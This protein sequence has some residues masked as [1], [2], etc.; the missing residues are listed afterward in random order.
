MTPRSSEE[1]IVGLLQR[2][3]QG[4]S[5]RETCRQSGIA[6]ETFYRWRRKYGGMSVGQAQ[7]LT[8]LETENRRLKKLVAELRIDRAA[9]R[10]AL[11]RELVSTAA[12]RQVTQRWQLAF[13]LSERRACRILGM[14]RSTFR[15]ERRAQTSGTAP[16][17]RARHRESPSRQE[18]RWTSSEP[19]QA[20]TAGPDRS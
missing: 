5:V 1:E 7:G 9:L 19:R 12:R 15:Y 18:E 14:D 8:R 20:P 17:K 2:A 10:D 16:A 4:E 13:S 6:L 3:E 11:S